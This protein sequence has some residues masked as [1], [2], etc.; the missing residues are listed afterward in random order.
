MPI[1]VTE[2]ERIGKKKH[3]PDGRH[4]YVNRLASGLGVELEGF[5][6]NS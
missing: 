6:G 3:P 1:I 2:P 4:A 5:W